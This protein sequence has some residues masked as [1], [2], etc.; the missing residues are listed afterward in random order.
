MKSNNPR[1]VKGLKQWL[2]PTNDK[3]SITFEKNPDGSV[4][5]M[6]KSEQKQ[7]IIDP[8]ITNKWD[9]EKL[10]R[11][12]ELNKINYIIYNRWLKPIFESG[13]DAKKGYNDKK[14]IQ[15][16][17]VAN[18]HLYPISK[19]EYELLNRRKVH[20]I[21][22]T[23]IKETVYKN[24]KEINEALDNNLISNI[25]LDPGSVSRINDLDYH[26]I[27]INKYVVLDPN[28]TDNGVLYIDTESYNTLQLFN[29]IGA[30]F[31]CNLS[32][33]TFSH[34]Y[35]ICDKYKLWSH[36]CFTNKPKVLFINKPENFKDIEYTCQLDL[37]KAFSSCLMNLPKVPI[38]NAKSFVRDF[39]RITYSGPGHSDNRYQGEPIN[40]NYFYLIEDVME[41]A[42]AYIQNGWT[43]GIR[44]SKILNDKKINIDYENYVQ[45]FKI[46]TVIEPVLVDNPFQD[47][48]R[49]LLNTGDRSAKFIINKFIGA[50]Q[51]TK[52]NNN[53]SLVFDNIINNEEATEAYNTGF[54]LFETLDKDSVLAFKVL[55]STKKYRKH[56]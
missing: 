11:F 37:I 29:K 54:Q 7:A 55:N 49:R 47:I 50:I 22:I 28:N 24:L 14:L 41:D 23:D 35:F 3:I 10:V 5:K 34:F 51:R 20:N 38:I 33:N 32:Y 30:S 53:Q 13:K 46:S 39:K 52:Y 43:T 27:L 9:V 36:H 17:I 44:L 12:L 42:A 8:K 2:K 31:E 40:R 15:R 25:S 56:F 21:N 48:I 1:V 19:R 18:K 4:G 16:F 6:I 26:E 45:Y